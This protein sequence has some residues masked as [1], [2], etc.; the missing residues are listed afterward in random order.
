MDSTIH[1]SRSQRWWDFIGFFSKFY[2]KGFPFKD[3]IVTNLDRRHIDK[4]PT[5]NFKKS[6]RDPTPGHPLSFKPERDIDPNATKGKFLIYG[7][8]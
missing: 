7:V 1:F 2:I 3:E 5:F 8:L 4:C 6:I